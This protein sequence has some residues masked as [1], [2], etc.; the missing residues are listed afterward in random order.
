MW[1]GTVR[2]SVIN[3]TS[4][5]ISDAEVQHALRAVNRQ[6]SEDFA[7]YWGLDAQLRLEGRSGR[8]PDTQRVRDMRG[9]AVLYL[10]DEEDMDGAV[11]Y[12]FSN[13]AGVPFGFVFT[14]ICR[15]WGSTWTAALSH[16]VLELL[17]DPLCNSLVRGPHP[18]DRRKR[19]FY[20]REMCDP[21]QTQT[22]FI[23]GVEVSNFVLPHYFT[24]DEEKG[25]RNDFLGDDKLRSFGVTDGGYVGF[26]DPEK[27]D[28]DTFAGGERGMKILGIKR[29]AG[30]G[31]RVG[32]NRRERTVLE[33]R[34]ADE[35]QASRKSTSRK[36]TARKS[37][38][39]SSA[40]KSS[41]KLT[42]KPSRRSS[43]KSTS[44]R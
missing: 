41:R 44:R 25:T 14:D 29:K 40:R 8:Q 15:E 34:Q 42:R 33:Q 1:E 10:W 2:I 43:R 20:W 27:K 21:V 24:E 7:P 26:W 32:R 35:A 5:K 13:Y 37:T 30:L 12:H 11:G 16:E 36:S 17:G 31:P 23:D 19:V 9:D 39:K 28:D 18:N 4:R 22:Y 3:H 38:R 6:I